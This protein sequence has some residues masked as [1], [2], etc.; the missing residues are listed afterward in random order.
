MN[1]QLLRDLLHETADRP[2]PTLFDDDSAVDAVIA[3]RRT[4]RRNRARALVAA[5]CVA[6]VA[7]V[8]PFVWPGGG[9]APDREAAGGD[10][11][12]F[13]WPTRGSLADD[14]ATIE[15]VLALPAIRNGSDALT[16]PRVAFAGDVPGVARFALVIGQDRTGA[17]AGQW[18]AGPVG[19][20]PSGLEPDRGPVPLEDA[21]SVSHVSGDGTRLLVLAAPGDTVE[22]SSRVEVDADGSLR[23]D[24]TPV[25]TEDGVAVAPLE[26]STEYGPSAIYR[27]LQDG[28]TVDSRIAPVPGFQSSAIDL[29]LLAPLDPLSEPP[30]PEAV[31]MATGVVVAQVGLPLDQLRLDLLYSGPLM[32]GTSEEAWVDA[33]V[34]AVTLPNGAVVVSTAWSDIAE[35]GAGT[36]GTCGMQSHPAGTPLDALSVAAV[37]TSVGDP[38][39]RV[40]VVYVGTAA[41][42]YE[43][44]DQDG[45]VVA[46]GNG[47]GLAT[48]EPAPTRAVLRV[49]SPEAEIVEQA[50]VDSVPDEIVDLAGRGAED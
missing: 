5:A 38:V 27:V 44:E 10:S 45:H 21:R 34:L 1:E 25:E 9:S 11:P 3:A 14:P 26:P 32:R 19:A 30:A 28:E 36:A 49:V 31:E 20:G 23:R 22:L 46:G 16:D 48:V 42:A 40:L 2:V 15:G 7:L 29:P 43:V 33:V 12:V 17:D 8:V 47:G 6:A 13:D 18:L 50:V 4:Q 24:Y 37:C 35:S 41:G 39:D